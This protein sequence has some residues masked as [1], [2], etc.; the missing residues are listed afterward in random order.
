[1]TVRVCNAPKEILRGMIKTYQHSA[2]CVNAFAQAGAIKALRSEESRRATEQMVEAYRERHALIMELID[3]SEFLLCTVPQG[4]FYCFPSYSFDKPSLKFAKELL[5]GIRVA[6]ARGVAFGMGPPKNPLAYWHTITVPGLF[7]LFFVLGWNLLGD[8][9]R[10][11]L[12]PRL[13]RR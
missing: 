8:A 7:M 3:Q 1:M 5:E 11:I 2:T 12:D 4:A 10:D 13:R 6:T 9:F